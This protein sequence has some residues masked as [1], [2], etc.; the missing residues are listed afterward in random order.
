MAEP[1]KAP[2]RVVLI[3]AGGGIG[4]AL[5]SRLLR[6]SPNCHV[7]GTSRAPRSARMRALADL[8]PDRFSAANCDLGSDESIR[9]LAAR[10]RDQM[11]SPDLVI[12]ASGLLH[13]PG[14]GPEKSHAQL[15][16]AWLLR[17]F[18]INCVGPLLAAASLVPLM[19]RNRLSLFVVLS[20]LV[21][22][23]TDNRL[24]GW[25]GYRAS[26]AAL[27]QGMK[28]LAVEC[29]RTHPGLCVLSI[30]PGT[31]DTPLSGPFTSRVAKEKLYSP[32]RTAARILRVLD[33][34]DVADSGAFLHW[35]GSELPY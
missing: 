14:L 8:F 5:A 10:V 4:G 21:G 3:G 24:G 11:G 7:L 17:Q 31:T 15:D 32:A 9:Q 34:S 6:S 26:K 23:I 1:R 29:R 33:A 35:D 20:A 2:R 13:E 19:P 30:H 25:Y 18:E 27:N 16:R 22:S 28:T 12:V